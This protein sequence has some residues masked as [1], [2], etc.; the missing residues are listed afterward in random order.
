M[1]IDLSECVGFQWDEGNARKNWDKHQV[2]C[3]ECEQPFFNQPLLIDADAAHSASEELRYH[4]FRCYAL[5]RTDA[6]RL[7]FVVFTVRENHIRVISARD[8]GR[9]E[10]RIYEKVTNI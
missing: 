3:P 8:M 9:R 5:G 7:L 6:D 2:T 1:V 10:R 4:T